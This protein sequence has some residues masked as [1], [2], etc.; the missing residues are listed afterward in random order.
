[1]AHGKGHG[2]VLIVDDEPSIRSSLRMMLKDE[3]Y[4]PATAS[5]GSEAIRKL[6]S[7]EF[8]V[9][10]LDLVMEPVGGMEVLKTLH[11]RWRTCAVV[12]MTGFA[13]IESAIS[14]LKLGAY[15]Y[16]LKPFKADELF[17]TVRKA[18]E[19]RKLELELSERE[20]Q[21]RESRRKYQTLFEETSDAVVV[22]DRIGTV[23]DA[24]TFATRLFGYSR[25]ELLEMSFFD[26]YAQ[27]DRYSAEQVFPSVVEYSA[28]FEIEF[29]RKSGSS[30]VGEMSAR[31]IE[32]DG[33]RVFQT[34]IRDI[35][36]RKRLVEECLVAKEGTEHLMSLLCASLLGMVESTTTA[37]SASK[38]E[39]KDALSSLAAQKSIIQ[40]VHT[41]SELSEGS[42]T[43]LDESIKAAIGTFSQAHPAV[44]VGYEPTDLKVKAGE[45]LESVLLWVL[46]DAATRGAKDI[47]IATEQ[48]G[49]NSAAQLCISDD[50]PCRQQSIG[51]HM[52]SMAA[53]RWEGEVHIQERHEGEPGGGCSVCMLLKLAHS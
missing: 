52:A 1:M 27:K 38:P 21:L 33:E 42:P 18:V 49:E 36:N 5:D 44:S 29:R 34:V 50:A 51:L 53:L 13:T 11:E 19:W 15:D 48:I 32:L 41:L 4:T 14:T 23:L 47:Q 8:D 12:V 17:N 39:V 46:D 20:R 24:N 9:V 7:E 22:F 2:K 40:Q 37:L 26:L 30:I 25:D 45:Q 6:E 16:L 31:S 10:L 35:T 28:Y 43:K 3:G